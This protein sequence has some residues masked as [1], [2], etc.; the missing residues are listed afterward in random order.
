MRY[1]Y[2]EGVA[3]IGVSTVSSKVSKELQA[4]VPRAN[5]FD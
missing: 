5:F 3:I 1:C 4:L 2:V